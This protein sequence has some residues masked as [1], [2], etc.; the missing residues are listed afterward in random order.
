MID[1]VELV[2][3]H[4]VRVHTTGRQSEL[5]LQLSTVVANGAVMP[6]DYIEKNGIDYF[7]QHPVGSG[8]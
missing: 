4:T 7:N 5:P 3:D 1:H 2:D 8:P 6:K